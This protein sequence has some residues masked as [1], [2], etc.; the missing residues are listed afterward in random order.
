MKKHVDVFLKLAGEVCS[1]ITEME[2]GFSFPPHM[3][4]QGPF[5]QLCSTRNPINPIVLDIGPGSGNDSIMA[6]L[7]GAR[8]VIAVDIHKKN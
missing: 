7:A 2:S 6:L 5:L 1:P 3:V 4:A 8:Q